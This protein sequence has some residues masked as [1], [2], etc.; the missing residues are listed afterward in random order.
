[1]ANNTKKKTD[2]NYN[3]EQLKRDF[4]GRRHKN[5][6]VFY[7][8]EKYMLSYYLGE[9]RKLVSP[10]TE[11]FNLHKFDGKNL[12][13][14][15][16]SEAIN[17]LPVFSEATVIEIR[18]FDFSKINEDVRSELTKILSDVPDYAHIVFVCDTVDFKLDGRVK[19]NA[20]LKKL[21]N[22]VQFNYQGEDI[23]SRWI[24]QHFRDYGKSISAGDTKY[25]SYITGGDMTLLLGE[26]SKISAYAENRMVTRKDIDAVVV[27]VIEA[28]GYELTDAILAGKRETAIKKLGDLLMINEAPHKILFIIATRIRQLLCARIYMDSGKSMKDFMNMCE[29][30]YDFQ[31]KGIYAAAKKL[32]VKD[33]A[34]LNGFVADTAFKLNSTP[35]EGDDLL[36][37]LLV[38]FSLYL[39]MA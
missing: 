12:S 14:N 31:A 15:E 8:E 10:G 11:E 5:I 18:D 20:A 24:P 39:R 35:Q 17:S 21:L 22:A 38:R 32:S 27:P 26:I 13:I 37:E 1:M 16:L 19:A 2:E 29:I 6:Y 4:I 7:G 34:K 36:K 25:L 3:F 9:L 30:K 33:C 28:Q 23:L